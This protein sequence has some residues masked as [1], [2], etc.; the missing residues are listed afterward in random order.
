MALTDSQIRNTK[1]AASAIKLADGGGLFLLVSPSGARL[2]R[3]RYRIGGKENLFAAGEYVQPQARESTEEAKARRSAGRLTLAEAR[4]ARHEWRQLVKQGV[5]PSHRRRA[6]MLAVQTQNASTFEAVANEWIA[7]KKSGW[8]PYYTRQVERFLAADAYP[9]IGRLPIRD[10]TP[11]HLL[12]VLHTIEGRGAASVALLVRQWS[13][14]VFRYAIATM[15]ADVDPASS[16]RGAIHRPKVVHRKPLDRDQIAKLVAAVEGYGGLPTTKIALR[17][18]LLLFTRTVELRAA[19]WSEF[20]LDRAEW[21]VP[22]ER[23][24]MGDEHVVPLSRQAVALLRELSKFTGTGEYLFPNRR[25]ANAC[26]SATTINRALEYLGFSGEGSIGFSAHGFRATASTILNESGFRPDVIERQLAHAERN[27][28]RASY[29][30]ATYLDERRALMQQWADLVDDMA[31]GSKK[32][33]T[34]KRR[35]A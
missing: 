6:E 8:T 34:M 1:P 3:Y 19:R 30:R 22:G 21:R 9:E 5:H 31:T 23:M 32:V 11:A 17:L 4:V 33:R 20:D 28:V 12:K 26:M 15:R 16:L 29:N 18:M 13:S 2:W 27:K 35:A 25:R 14:A 10:V 7:K 24:K